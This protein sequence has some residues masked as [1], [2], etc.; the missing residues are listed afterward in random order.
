MFSNPKRRVN[1]VF[2]HCSASDHKHHDDVSVIRDWHVN[3]R[4]WSDVGYHFFIRKNGTV[5]VGRPI[6][7]IPAAQSSHNP[8]SIAVCLHGLKEEKFTQAQFKS[9][10]ALCREI[11]DA[12]DGKVTFH[13][14]REV[15]AKA[16]PVFDYKA[17][18]KLDSKGRLG[19]GG[20]STES[21]VSKPPKP[22]TP[23]YGDSREFVRAFQ[24][25][26]GLTTDGIAGPNTYAKLFA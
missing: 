22:A 11:H 6:S 20:G 21:P 5:Q 25:K 1:K 3:G 14:H 23:K 7:K 16:C 24:K 10:N 15:A 2:I 4:G 13:G 26:H 12:Y 8:G 17:V 19:A 9:L 18:L